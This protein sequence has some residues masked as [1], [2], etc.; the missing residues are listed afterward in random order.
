MAK[1]A[2]ASGDFTPVR[3]F[4]L[5]TFK[6]LWFGTQWPLKMCVFH[7]MPFKNV[8]LGDTDLIYAVFGR[9]TPYKHSIFDIQCERRAAWERSRIRFWHTLLFHIVFKTCKNA[10]VL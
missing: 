4:G 10:L 5:K 7:R 1:S 6:K 2:F 8:Y 3:L 9:N